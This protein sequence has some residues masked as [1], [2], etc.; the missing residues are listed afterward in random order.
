M[1]EIRK[2]A[3]PD[4]PIAETVASR[5]EKELAKDL[6]WRFRDIRDWDN[7]WNAENISKKD[8]RAYFQIQKYFAGLN[9]RLEKEYPELTSSE[10]DGVSKMLHALVISRDT[11][12]FSRQLK[13]LGG[14]DQERIDRVLAKMQRENKTLS[15]ADLDETASGL[16]ALRK[17]HHDDFIA[18]VNKLGGLNEQR[19][20]RV[21]GA[22]QSECFGK[23]LNR[24]WHGT[25][26]LEFVEIAP[27]NSLVFSN[28]RLFHGDA[29]ISF[30]SDGKVGFWCECSI[31]RGK[32]GAEDNTFYNAGLE[33]TR[34]ILSKI[35]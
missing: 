5:Q 33:A 12:E 17:N 20:A 16:H 35:K 30:H 3:Y 31:C 8:L 25:R 32:E 14:T 2:H 22:I 34:N 7:S 1:D 9:A 19:I 13:M 6:E 24:F 28:N 18:L 21:F 15:Q 29:S 23:P 10:R 27:N 26:A 4:K 11:M